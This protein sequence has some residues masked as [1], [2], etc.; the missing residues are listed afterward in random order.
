MKKGKYIPGRVFSTPCVLF[1]YYGVAVAVVPAGLVGV[2]VCS[3]NTTDIKSSNIVGEGN[4]EM[5]KSYTRAKK[6][7]AMKRPSR[8]LMTDDIRGELVGVVVVAVVPAR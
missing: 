2:D 8:L 5:H 1:N 7:V 4:G 6:G 3:R